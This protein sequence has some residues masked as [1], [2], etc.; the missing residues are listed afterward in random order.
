MQ[1]AISHSPRMILAI[2]P[3]LN[4]LSSS[5]RH[6]FPNSGS[7]FSILYSYLVEVLVFRWTFYE[8]KLFFSLLLFIL[9]D[10]CGQ[11]TPC[12][13]F[14]ARGHQLIVFKSSTCVAQLLLTIRRVS[15][16]LFSLF[17]FLVWWLIFRFLFSFLLLLMFS[18]FFF[19]FSDG[20]LSRMCHSKQ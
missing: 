9:F 4:R 18:F 17:A 7:R 15:F 5:T 20:A 8:I 19:S 6:M 12:G 13:L 11:L 3:S 1:L 10:K 14:C 16:L 2:R